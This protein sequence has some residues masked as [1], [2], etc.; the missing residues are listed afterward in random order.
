ME[1]DVVC[2]NG[3]Y[4]LMLAA[5]AKRAGEDNDNGG[6]QQPRTRARVPLQNPRVPFPPDGSLKADARARS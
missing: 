1:E 3:M 4:L 6:I 5:R 2:G